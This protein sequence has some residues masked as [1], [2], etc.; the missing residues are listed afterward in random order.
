MSPVQLR[1]GAPAPGWA[2]TLGEAVF[3]ACYDG[4]PDVCDPVHPI[5]FESL[6]L[7]FVHIFLRRVQAGASQRLT[8]MARHRLARTMLAFLAATARDALYLEFCRYR[9]AGF[10]PL[11]PFVYLE[12]DALLPAFRVPDASRWLGRAVRGASDVWRVG[13]P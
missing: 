6:L 13:L 5:P 1:V 3:E 4:L 12:S 7:P 8:L 9:L 11:A 10:A 2:E